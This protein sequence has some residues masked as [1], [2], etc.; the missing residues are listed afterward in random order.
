MARKKA[1]KYRDPRDFEG[2]KDDYIVQKVV[3]D[4][5]ASESYI[6]GK[7]DE[8]ERYYQLYRSYIKAENKRTTGSNLSIPYIFSIVETIVPKIVM[9]MLKSRPFLVYK[10]VKVEDTEKAAK[11]TRLVDYQMTN[12]MSGTVKLTEVIKSCVIYGTAI[13][14]QPWKFEE[15]KFVKRK[16][17]TVPNP[18]T[19][20]LEEV[21]VEVLM[22]GVKYDAPDIENITL[23]QFFVDPY[24]TTIDNSE[25]CG[26]KYFM[27][28]HKLKTGEEQGKYKNINKISPGNEIQVATGATERLSS[29]G[30]DDKPA[31]DAVE[32]IEYW[33]NDWKI[34]IANRTVCIQAEPNPYYHREKP[35]TRW[36]DIPVP[37]EFYGIG[38]VEVSEMLQYEMNTVRN[39]RIDNTSFA[40]NRMYKVL[41]SANIEPSQLI[42]RPNGFI[43]LDEMSDLEQL[44]ITGAAGVGFDE[45]QAIKAD[46]NDVTGVHNQDRG[47]P[48]S[49]RETATTATIMNEGSTERFSFRVILLEDDALAKMGMQLAW[50]NRQFVDTDT[51]IRV[52]GDN[53]GDTDKGVETVTPDDLDVDLDLV[54]VGSASDP[55]ANK[56]V[57]QNQLIQML[58][59]AA[60]PINAQYV[61]TPELLKS[62]FLAFDL[63]DVDKYIQEPA[64]VEPPQPE[65][66]GG[67]APQGGVPIG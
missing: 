12:K 15:K 7:K 57:R 10:P 39:Q 21:E 9:G 45:E 46:M 55:S 35:Y 62:V 24:G 30:K 25:Y 20:D 13:S 14:K 61:N 40:L 63:K 31:K 56:E 49:R 47:A 23:E 11:M 54:A 43:E 5:I 27:P 19:G 34:L 64:P 29:I 67:L 66:P 38:D 42:S 33:T 51:E 8:W 52:T 22:Q 6:E 17:Q 59:V 41:R 18:D 36:V 26:D 16:T 37:N 48:T 60:N 1:E 53:V 2:R 50:L 58:N 32:I 28:L 65:I 3:D 4:V 44:D